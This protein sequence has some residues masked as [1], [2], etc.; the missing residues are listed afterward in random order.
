LDEALDHSAKS[1]RIVKSPLLTRRDALHD[2]SEA[3]AGPRPGQ[4]DDERRHT[5]V[6]E[7][8]AH[9]SIFGVVS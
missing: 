7:R 9:G 2:A 6:G 4:P 3:A 8:F 1:F 5:V